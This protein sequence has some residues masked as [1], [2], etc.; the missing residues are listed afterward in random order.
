[1]RNGG[2]ILTFFD[3]DYT[4]FRTFAMV[5]VKRGKTVKK[6]LSSR[7]YNTYT[8]KSGES[9]DYT[10]F[11]SAEFFRKTS[12]PIE[13]VFGK[14][15]RILSQ[16]HRSP[17]SRVV[18][19]TARSS[20]DDHNIFLETF[21][22]VGFDVDNVQ[23]E[24]A[25]DLH[26]QPTAKAKTIAARK[27]IENSPFARVRMFDDAVDNLDGFLGL[28]PLYPHIRFEAHHITPGGRINAYS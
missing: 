24:F 18:V 1:M 25:G 3:I 2:P 7:D 27:H 5:L 14:A 11:R 9:Y 26:I 20:F 6:R 8:L 10:E 13:S 19:I 28:K 12:Q 15:K 17:G 16:I 21:R 4:L 22:D 23:F